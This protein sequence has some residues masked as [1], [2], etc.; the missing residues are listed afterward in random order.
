MQVKFLK[1]VVSFVASANAVAIVD[2]LYGKE[3]VNEFLIAKKLKITINQA[4]NILYKLAE[5]GLVSFNRKKDKKNG[6]WYTYFWTLDVNKSLEVL[7]TK[8]V[9]EIESLEKQLE[10]RKIKRFYYSPGADIEYSEE[11]ALEHNF[12]CPETGEVM[13]LMDDSDRI[14]E[15]IDKIKLLKEKLVGVDEELDKIKKKMDASRERKRKAEE[16]KKKAER[17]VKRKARL[18]EK[19]KELK[20]KGKLPKAK[21]KKKGKVSKKKPKKPRK[22]TKKKT[23]KKR[24]VSKTTT[25]KK[26]SRSQKRNKKFKKR[27][28]I[29]KKSMRKKPIK[30]K[31]IKARSS[32]KVKKN[33]RR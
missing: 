15:I 16:R 29:K 18:R 8:I 4:R 17:A 6:G 10:S 21:V 3:N 23:A 12:I 19:E 28:I 1:D 2:L 26:S 5:E 7:K 25:F 14:K 31:I 30:R 27:K 11:S 32:R 20:K 9:K 24:P 13:E 33:R 22:T